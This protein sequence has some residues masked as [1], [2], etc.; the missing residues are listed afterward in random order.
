MT[1]VFCDMRVLLFLVVFPI[2]VYEVICVLSNFRHQPS[3]YGNSSNRAPQLFI[4][5][6]KNCKI[7][8]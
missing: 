4:S 2:H 8:T 1:F 7:N 5:M 3:V 6:L